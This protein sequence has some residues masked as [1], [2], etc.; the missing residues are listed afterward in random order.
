V[1]VLK[2]RLGLSPL[3]PAALVARCCGIGCLPWAPGSWGSLAALPL[4]WAIAWRFGPAALIAAALALFFLGWWAAETMGRASGIADDSSIVVDEVAGQWLTLAVAPLDPLAYAAGFLLFRLFDIVKPWPVR[5][6]DRAL[7]GGFGVM[8]DD[9]LA[10]LYA[11]LSLYFLLAA[12]AILG[13]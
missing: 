11:A 6:A 10:A 3:H 9:I 1:G 7:A 13:R 2:D 8:A 12:G 5:W 4:A